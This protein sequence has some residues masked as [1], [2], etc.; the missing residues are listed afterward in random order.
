LT[1]FT[2]GVLP[3][4]QLPLDSPRRSLD[5]FDYTLVRATPAE[6][7]RHV[8]P[9]FLV[10]GRWIFREEGGSREDLSRRAKAALQRVAVQERLL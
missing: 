1:T 8:V 3:F 9:D 6:I 7:T 5:G 4:E 10:R 2:I